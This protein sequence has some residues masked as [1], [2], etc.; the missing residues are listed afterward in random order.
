MSDRLHDHTTLGF[1]RG[2]AACAQTERDSRR[3]SSYPLV[4]SRDNRSSLT[5]AAATEP[6]ARKSTLKEG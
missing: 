4:E 3:L 2:C 1:R 5:A 6:E